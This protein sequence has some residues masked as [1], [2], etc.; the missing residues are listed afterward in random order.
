MTWKDGAIYSGF[1]SHGYANGEGK[2][3]YANGSVYNGHWLDNK[4]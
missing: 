1:W 4:K 2:F 3:Q